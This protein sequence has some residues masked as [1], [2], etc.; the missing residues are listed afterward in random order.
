[1][2][3]SP[4]KRGKRGYTINNYGSKFEVAAGDIPQ[5]T[6]EEKQELINNNAEVI[7][8]IADINFQDF[9]ALEGTMHGVTFAPIFVKSWKAALMRLI[10]PENKIVDVVFRSTS[11]T[12]FREAYEQ[13]EVI[14]RN[15]P[16]VFMV[17]QAAGGEGNEILINERI[18]GFEENYNEEE[19]VAHIKSP[20]NFE[21]LCQDIFRSFDEIAQEPFHM[22][23]I[24]ATGGHNVIFNKHTEKFQFFDIDTLKSSDKSPE[25]KFM[26]FADQF[27]NPDSCKDEQ[28]VKFFVRMIQ[29]Y[30]EKYNTTELKVEKETISVFGV[31]S[32]SETP[33]QGEGVIESHIVHPDDPSYIKE[34]VRHYGT[35][36]AYST[37]KNMPLHILKRKEVKK[38]V[39]DPV[40]MEAILADDLEAVKKIV[41]DLIGEVIQTTTTVV[42]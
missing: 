6:I 12:F 8:H 31:E 22:T 40:V 9:D 20:E 35:T 41:S 24:T 10:F 30:V 38:R 37:R 23:D 5:L 11:S 42:S 2:I 19:F 14:R 27:S 7:K 39:I 33:L 15:F 28:R 1:M 25:E 34:Y 32:E 16:R 17:H 3:G 4:E 13:N 36:P 26:E 21:K 18:D 29:L